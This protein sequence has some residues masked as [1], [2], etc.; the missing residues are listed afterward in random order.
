M[1][2]TSSGAML[3]PALGVG[4][5]LGGRD[6][7]GVGCGGDDVRATLCGLGGERRVSRLCPPGGVDGVTGDGEARVARRRAAPAAPGAGGRASPLLRDCLSRAGVVGPLVVSAPRALGV[8]SAVTGPDGRHVSARRERPRSAPARVGAHARH[9]GGEAGDGL[10]GGPR[11]R[12]NCTLLARWEDGDTDPWLLGTALAPRA[13]EAC[14]SGLRAWME[15]GFKITKRGGWQWQRTRTTDPQ[16][17]ARLWLAVAVATLWLLSGGGLAAETLPVGTLLTL[18][19]NRKL[20]ARPRRATPLRLVSAFRQGWGS[21][22]V[23]LLNHHRFPLGRFAPE[24]WPSTAPVH[25]QG[26]MDELLLAA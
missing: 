8:A 12:L 26:R 2:S 18:P 19:A 16:R 6:S 23:A 4:A 15:Q 7:A 20:G 9:P 22:L 11:R 17:A 1:A 5:E 10:S 3:C 24:P 21:I 25:T 14:W 13:G